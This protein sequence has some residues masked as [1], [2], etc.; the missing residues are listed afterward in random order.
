MVN[1]MAPATSV[2]ASAMKGDKTL[3]S[4]E[5]CGRLTSSMRIMPPL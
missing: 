3:N 4:A 1:M 5:R 2:S